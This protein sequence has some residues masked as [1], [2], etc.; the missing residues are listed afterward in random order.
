MGKAKGIHQYA[1][2]VGPFIHTGTWY[3]LLNT[4]TYALPV[5]TMQPKSKNPFGEIK[6]VSDL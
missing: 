1:G 2:A 4:I 3:T 6:V 5:G